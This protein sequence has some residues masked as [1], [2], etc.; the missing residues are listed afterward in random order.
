MRKDKKGGE[1][2]HAEKREVDTRAAY[3]ADVW[4]MKEQRK[5]G[6]AA[7]EGKFPFWRVSDQ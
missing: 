1:Q 6:E 7:G 2:D 5:S 4:K 3:V